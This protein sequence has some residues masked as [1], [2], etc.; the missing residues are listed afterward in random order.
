MLLWASFSR[1]TYAPP[2]AA[3]VRLRLNYL[4]RVIREGAGPGTALGELTRQN[5]EWGLFTLSFTSYALANL[6]QHD[7]SLRP[8]AA[9]YIEPGYQR[10]AGRAYS[11]A[12]CR[13]LAYPR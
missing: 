11:P 6:A 4:E 13:W 12:L 1:P 8:E 3:K 2:D 10:S 9:R 5:P 7:P